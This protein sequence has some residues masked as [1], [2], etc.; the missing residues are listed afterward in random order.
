MALFFIWV[1]GSMA[2]FGLL[3]TVRMVFNCVW[4]AR[5]WWRAWRFKRYMARGL[6]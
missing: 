1:L 5:D 3:M 4:I 6:K 2:V